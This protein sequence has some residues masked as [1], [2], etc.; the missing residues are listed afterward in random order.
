MDNYSAFNAKIFRK[1]VLA[2]G[3]VFFPFPAPAASPFATA[4]WSTDAHE[5]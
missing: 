2:P 3:I 4:R 5:I 1:P